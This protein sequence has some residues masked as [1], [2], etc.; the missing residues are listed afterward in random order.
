[1]QP[2]TY[3]D[4]VVT[5]RPLRA[6]DI[7]ADLAAKD[8]EQID[9]LWDP[10]QRGAWEAMTGPEQRAR[11]L[12][13][14]R[15][16]E[17]S[18]GPGPKWAFAADLVDVAYVAYVDCDLA[19]RHAPLGHANIAYSAH[20][21]FRGRGYVSRA[22][23]LVFQFLEDN[24]SASEAHIIVDIKNGASLRVAR[25]VGASPVQEW[26]NDE[27]RTMVRHVVVLPRDGGRAKHPLAGASA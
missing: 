4:G 1:V 19:N 25:A 21:S 8:D 16:A 3:S 6:D 17:D 10:G 14:L 12:S 18:F 27:G 22:V 7:E 13:T 23:R 9:W 20:P 26:V 15:Q 24:T 5:I 11:A 2:I